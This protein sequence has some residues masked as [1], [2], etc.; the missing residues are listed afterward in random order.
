[1]PLLLLVARCKTRG[2]GRPVR[3][4]LVPA[5]NFSPHIYAYLFVEMVRYFCARNPLRPVS[6]FTF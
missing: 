4:D 2:L 6:Y 3:E 5:A 1:M